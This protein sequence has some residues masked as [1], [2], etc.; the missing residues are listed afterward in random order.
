LKKHTGHCTEEKEEAEGEKR[1]RRT[2]RHREREKREK[3]RER[4]R[5]EILGWRLSI[6]GVVEKASYLERTRE[7]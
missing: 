2:H 1:K 3:E 4:E 6:L 7:I 5:F